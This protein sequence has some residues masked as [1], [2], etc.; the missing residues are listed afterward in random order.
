MEYIAEYTNTNYLLYN[1]KIINR[2]LY[3]KV[4]LMCI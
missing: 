3:K 4:T 1:E 2:F